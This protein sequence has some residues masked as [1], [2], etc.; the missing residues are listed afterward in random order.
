MIEMNYVVY[1]FWL[2]ELAESRKIWNYTA[3]FKSPN[4]LELDF[5]YFYFLRNR[6]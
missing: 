1:I 5:I 3:I 4:D 6:K 2:Q